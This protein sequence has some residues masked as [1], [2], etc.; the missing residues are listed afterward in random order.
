M[1]LAKV[2]QRRGAGSLRFMALTSAM[3]SAMA[4]RA[5]MPRSG[6]AQ[7]ALLP[8]VVS[9]ISEALAIMG[10]GRLPMTFFS[11]LGHT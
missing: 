4:L 10:P 11:I 5:S 2:A 7:W 9:V 3:I 1:D 6:R 8:W